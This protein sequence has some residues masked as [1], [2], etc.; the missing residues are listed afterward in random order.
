MAAEIKGILFD[1]G[2]T[3]VRPV[4]GQWFPSPMFHSI[5]ETHGI[6]PRNFSALL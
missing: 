5:L 3:L 6:E 1:S 4:D 2:D